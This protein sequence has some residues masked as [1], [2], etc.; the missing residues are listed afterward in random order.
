M[1]ETST[2]AVGR[3]RRRGVR[4][5]AA[6]VLAAATGTVLAGPVQPFSDI[7][8]ELAQMLLRRL[9]GVLRLK[10]SRLL[11]FQANRNRVDAVLELLPDADPPTVMQLDGGDAVALQTLCRGT[12]TWQRLEDLRHAGARGLMVLPVER[13]L[14]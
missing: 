14:A 10:D 11:M 9:D 13:S 1:T 8:G 12:M 5:A 7:R 3:I 2:A 6:V 4:A